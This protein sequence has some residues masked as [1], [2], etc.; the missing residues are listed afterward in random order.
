M[1]TV[2]PSIAKKQREARRR[3]TRPG[4]ARVLITLVV[5]FVGGYGLAYG[6]GSFAMVEEFGEPPLISVLGAI[7]GLLL[8]ILGSMVWSVTAMKRTDI[9][10]GYGAAAVLVGAGTGLLVSAAPNGY[11]ALAATIAVA[12]LAVG[13]LCLVLGVVGATSR[14]RQSSREAEILRS[15]TQTTATVSDKGYDFFRES[16][17]ILATVT[18]TFRDLQGTQRWV[19]KP[20]L[21]EQS[22]PIVEGQETRLWYDAT[23]PGDSRAIVVELARDHAFRR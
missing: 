16:S 15:G 12:L 21:V 8:T 10:F 20:M 14:L 23:N 1:S 4:I 13:V 18:F 11:P 22:S 19:Q 17:R 9:G 7:G 3:S 6:W 2:D 5:L